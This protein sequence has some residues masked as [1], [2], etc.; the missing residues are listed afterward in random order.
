MRLSLR[1]ALL[2]VSALIAAPMPARIAGADDAKPYFLVAS[3]DMG[4][5]VFRDSVIMMV[6]TTD[7]PLVAGVIINEPTGTSA[8]EL[9]PHVPSLK[10]DSDGA[11]YGGPIDNGVPTLA[12]RTSH[13]PDRATQIIEDLYVSTDSETIAQVLKDRKASPD[14]RIFIGRAQWLPE[15]LHAEIMQGAWYVV[16]ADA[17]QVFS[18]DPTH[19]WHK[20]VERGQLQET[21]FILP[22]ARAPQ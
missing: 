1:I 19:L 15:Q 22:P 2:L 16:P 14:L 4:D 5:P 11:Y 3:P 12:I 8:R 6:P 9:F 10:D 20:L 13:P 7:A 18:T 17:D 21:N